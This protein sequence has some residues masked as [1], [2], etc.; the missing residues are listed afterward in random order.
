MIFKDIIEKIDNL[1]VLE[2]LIKAYPD[3]KD[4]KECYFNMI[5]KLK[6]K[7]PKQE[8]EKLILTVMPTEDFLEEN[9]FY[10]NVFGYSVEDGQH[11]A[12]E[13]TDWDEWLG[14]EVCK[15]SV[16][17]YGE[18]LFVAHC[19]YEMSFISFEEETIEEQVEDLNRM[20]K[21]IE[22][23]TAKT[24]PME[25]VYRELGLEIPPRPTE[26]EQ[27]ETRQKFKRVQERNQK[28]ENEFLSEYKNN[29]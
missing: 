3:Q 28:I 27:E 7:E 25:E 18:D 21:E 1:K 16:E 12:L 10:D 15:K 22:E 6:I 5:E 26:E 13:F 23:G 19:L 2:A 4:L 24:I 9:E 20:S 11:Y 29:L 17:H 8:D 14:F